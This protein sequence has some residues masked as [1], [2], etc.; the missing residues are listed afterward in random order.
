MGNIFTYYTYSGASQFLSKYK[1]LKP[2]SKTVV[3]AG[4]EYMH[5]LAE[6]YMDYTA[7]QGPLAFVQLGGGI[8]ADFPICVVPHL[9]KDYL[10]DETLE[11]QSKEIPAWAGFIE[12]YN[13]H[14]SLGSYTGA[15][16]KE[17]ITWEKLLPNAYYN[18]IWGDFTAHFPDIAALIL[19]K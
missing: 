6:W 1:Q 4:F 11:V 2:I 15:G 18:Q 3:R 9:K 5:A 17:K 14:M 19:G 12:I 16:G 7:K 8:A 10:A 13:S